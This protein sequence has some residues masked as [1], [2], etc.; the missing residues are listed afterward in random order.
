MQA[1]DIKDQASAGTP[2]M[3]GATPD[4]AY[5]AHP[6]YAAH[7]AYADHPAYGANADESGKYA[8]APDMNYADDPS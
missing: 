2:L 5:A 6:S 7:P 4:G 1:H 8:D 3:Y